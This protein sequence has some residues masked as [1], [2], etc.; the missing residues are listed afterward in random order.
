MPALETNRMKTWILAPLVASVLALTGAPPA[1]A[2]S[3][4][5]GN[6]AIGGGGYVTAVVPSKTQ[7][8][9]F[10]ART[11]VGGAYRWDATNA[12]WIP[13][14]DHLSQDDVGLYHVESLALDPNNSAVVYLVAGVPY[15]SNGKTVVMRST[16]YGATWSRVT[17]VSNL[18]R[19]HGNGSAR[20]SGERLQ[21]DPGNS[22]VLYVG[23]RA[24]GLFKS[25]DAGA[26]FSR[27]TSLPVTTTPN[28]AGISFVLLDPT[29]VSNGA[30]QRII[31]GV[32]RYGSVGTNLYRSDNAGASFYAVG[33]APSAFMPSR[34]ALASDGNL[35]IA[36]GNGAGPNGGAGADNLNPPEPLDAGG[37]WKYNMSSGSWT[38][39][40]PSNLGRAYGGV[41]VDPANAQRII[42][43]T[44][45][46]WMQQNP[47]VWGDH[48]LLST[49]GGAT[50][51][52]LVAKGFSLDPNGVSW[53]ST[54]S[55]HWSTDIQFDPFDT[56]AAW[57]VSGNGVF[58]SANV[59]AAAPT[60]TFTV[61]GLEETV[62]LDIASIP[63]GP[64]VTVIGDFDGF[65]HTGSLDAYGQVHSPRIGTTSGLAVAAGSTS[66][67]VRVGNSMKRSSDTGATWTD[68]G[69][70]R[71]T[72]GKVALSANGGALLHTFRNS[73]G[74]Y[75]T[76]RSTN[77]TTSSPT[78][79][80]VSG[81]S[82]NYV[83]P[84]ADPVNSNKF[85]VY[86]RGSV[87]VSTN[88][89]ASFSTTATLADWGQT[90]IRTAPGREG[91]VWVP[92]NGSGLARSTNSGTSFST[93]ANV[94][95][96]GAVGFG[97]AMSGSSY[98]T[99]FIWGTVGTGK[100]GIY[101]STDAGA[102]WVRVNDDAHQFGGPGNGEF[103]AG[104]M[105]T[106]GRVYMS[107]VGRGLI[108]GT[109]AGGMLQARHSSKCL[110]VNGAST[111]SGTALIQWTCSGSGNQQWSFEDAGG[112]WSRLKVAHSGQCLDLSSQSTAN[113]T[114][115]VQ[116]T[117]NG[118]NSQQWVTE[119]MGSGYFRI[120]SRFSGLCVDVN[121]ASTA[122]GASVIQWA[123]G[124]GNN[125]Q[126]RNF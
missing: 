125:Q 87:R 34:A 60:W 51:T 117:C 89:G 76:F 124:T 11:D 73:D 72:G 112:G 24:N 118:N 83:V 100:R 50:W 119:D 12:K 65:R 111:S 122:D 2:Q 107:S 121:A 108:Y 48:F 77:Y 98:P 6:V 8:N 37:V 79:T 43:S 46:T 3:Y 80:A 29:S 45:N 78:W 40:T 84:E 28:N 101:R 126:W 113:G 64:L 59:D 54:E 110:D 116:A 52:D 97:K 25:T 56:K 57:V 71:G 99:V 120:K 5:W 49:N 4:R 15:Y 115:L 36:Y 23:S 106:E 7:R 94:S 82:T 10:Y 91:D 66:T 44:S 21:V 90:R 104:D 96:A 114:T 30:A 67:L 95:F 33:N 9:L 14:L 61:K 55:I 68:V 41:S 70:I 58:R 102:N 81:L 31:V 17:D 63:G 93:I 22:N 62:P 26:S 88:G 35:Y 16:D 19:A 109:P 74:T 39:V 13:L 103:I 18:W 105:N 47:N 38:N 27:V 85:Y 32:S 53:I 86:D 42:V 75:S 69:N 20:G 1:Q 123:C 92:L